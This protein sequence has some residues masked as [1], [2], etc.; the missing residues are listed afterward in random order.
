[1][2]ENWPLSREGWSLMRG[3]GDRRFDCMMSLIY[4]KLELFLN[5]PLN[6]VGEKLPFILIA[7][8]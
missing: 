3:G 7:E 8:E 5:V 1:M 6:L 2:L 4:Q